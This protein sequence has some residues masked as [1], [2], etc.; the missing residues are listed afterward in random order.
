MPMTGTPLWVFPVIAFLIANGCGER[1]KKPGT[2]PAAAKGAW[3]QV[4]G[5]ERYQLVQ[6]ELELARSKTPYLI[7]DFSKK[8]LRLKLKGAVV[9]NY[10]IEFAAKDSAEVGSFVK[11]YR[12]DNPMPL[13]VVTKKY[14]FA[15]QEMTPDSV[16][17]IVAGV[18]NVTPETLQRDIPARFQIQWGSDLTMDVSTNIEGKPISRFKNTMLDVAQKLNRPFGESVLSIKMQPMAAVTL[19]HA[20]DAGTSTIFYPPSISLK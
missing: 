9:W 12:E 6:A 19:Y 15:A 4:A 2:A 20:V 3:N 7:V 13:R 17:K 5:Q 14:L 18:L 8:E 1:Q 10:P 16:L 11:R